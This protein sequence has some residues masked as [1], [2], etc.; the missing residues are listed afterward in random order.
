MGCETR[1]A[2]IKVTLNLT[3]KQ[4]PPVLLAEKALRMEPLVPEVFQLHTYQRLFQSGGV[5]LS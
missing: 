3:L 2:E 1:T 4:L 5:F